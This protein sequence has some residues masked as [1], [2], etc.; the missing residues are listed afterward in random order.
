MGNFISDDNTQE[1]LLIIKSRHET[2]KKLNPKIKKIIF[3]SSSECER[4]KILLNDNLYVQSIDLSKLSYYEDLNELPSNLKKLFLPRNYNKK[5][6]TI[7]KKLEELNCSCD[8]YLL[9]CNSVSNDIPTNLKILR[10]LSSSYNNNKITNIFFNPNLLELEFESDCML[11]N[12]VLN[13]L[14]NKLIKLKL[15]DYSNCDLAN[16]PT[17]LKYLI[18][19]KEYTYNLDMLPES[20][21][22]IEFP[23]LSDTLYKLNVL[24]HN[25]PRGLEHLNLQFQ[26]KYMQ[27]ISNLPDAIKYLEIGEYELEIKKLPAN[28]EV[29]SICTLVQFKH[30]KNI[31]NP[32]TNK[33]IKCYELVNIGKFNIENNIQI[34]IPT[35]LT[36]I[37]WWDLNSSVYTFVKN[38]ELGYWMEQ[39]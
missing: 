37:T 3:N 7:P 36:R 1:D 38:P 29:L 34:T 17:N 10:L 14:P 27:S 11:T 26:N 28:L 12:I 20:I 25:L 21:I 16:L 15:P 32:I 13:N 23:E 31:I 30:I 8:Y 4:T 24:L 9:L 35:N 2:I 18:L 6:K 33:N 22:F 39:D 19:G 5:I